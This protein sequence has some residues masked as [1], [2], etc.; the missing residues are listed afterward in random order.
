MQIAPCFFKRQNGKVTAL[1]IYVDDM[2][3]TGNDVDKMAKL[4]NCLSAAFDMKYLDRLKYF[5]GCQPINTPITRNHG[6]EDL[7][8]QVP[9][10]KG[11]YQRLVGQFIYFSH[12]QPCIAYVSVPGRGLNHTKII[13]HCD[14]EWGARGERRCSTTGYFTFIGGNLVTWKSKKQRLSHCLVQ[15][16]NI[17]Q[18]SKIFKN[19]FG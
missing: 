19:C 6:S 16:L 18:W 2:I 14:S 7:P 10:N 15:K 8:D 1:I 17:G 4:K 9:T 13:G 12:R 3:V 5:L 11:R